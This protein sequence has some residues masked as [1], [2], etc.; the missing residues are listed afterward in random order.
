ME[1]SPCD[2]RY[3]CRYRYPTHPIILC[4]SGAQ[5]AAPTHAFVAQSDEIS[6]TDHG[7]LV[8]QPLGSEQLVGSVDEQHLALGLRP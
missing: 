2:P 4:V 5:P 3:R 1:R 7:S 6:P 8:G